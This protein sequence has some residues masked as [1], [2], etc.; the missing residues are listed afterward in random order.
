MDED[1]CH[2]QAEWPNEGKWD[3]TDADVTVWVNAS[4]I[5]CGAVI[6]VEGEVIENV[7]W[8]RND[9]ESHI[10]MTGLTLWLREQTY[11]PAVRLKVR[12]RRRLLE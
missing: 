7:S 11:D 5:A 8:L 4:S 6:T 9:G 1:M 3:V 2:D 12:R 10:N